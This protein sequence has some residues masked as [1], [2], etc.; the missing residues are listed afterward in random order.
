MNRPDAPPAPIAPREIELKLEIDPT[1]I[2][3]LTKQPLIAEADGKT[4]RQVSTYFDT[5]GQKLRKS[6]IALRV[7]EIDHRF[8]QTVKGGNP[9]SGGMFD[10]PE[11]EKEIDGPTP[12]PGSVAGTPVAAL[13]KR[14]NQAQLTPMFSAVVDRTVWT[15][16]EGASEIEMVLDRGEIR[17]D[18]RHDA[19]AEVELELRRGPAEDMF[20]L[21]HR[22]AASTPLRLGVL[23]KNERGY[24]LRDGV[25]GKPVKAIAAA[26][27][28]EMTA[29]AAFRAIASSCI[30]QF[31]LNEPLFV[32]DHHGGA[33]HQC[34][35][36][37]RRLRSAFSMFGGI[38]ADDRREALVEGVRWISGDLG[39]ARDLDVFINKQMQKGAVSDALR[40][41][42]LAQRLEAF[43]RA[44]AALNSHRFRTLMLD[45]AEWLALGKWQRPDNP[46]RELRDQPV[47]G[48]AE[49]ALDRFWRKV[50][51]G[52]R[53]LAEIDDEARHT[54][55]IAAKKL[56]Y[57]SEFFAPLYHGEKSKRRDTFIG[58]LEH[59]QEHLGDLN[60][61]VTARALADR[62]PGVK[63]QEVDR[64]ALLEAAEKA[65]D[66]LVEV[67][68]FW[69]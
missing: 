3:E 40:I 34:R 14:D 29:G 59:L 17:V 16:H 22:L 48:F 53:N 66:R 4:N 23:A 68:P 24:L 9:D 36:S 26:V 35:V 12:T 42:A 47:E 38:A 25:G 44:I 28:P 60:D 52:G 1:D 30:R 41:E 27:A 15:I 50:R 63:I 64:S 55:R 5:A 6:G 43:E 51:K 61:M 49:A 7:R 46:A 56:R 11:W 58:A 21:A 69:R 67:G 18:D 62:F 19:I 54:V 8:V 37:M 13:I 65:H 31:R 20:S 57:G 33:L 2:A 32:R 39:E 10:R 45:L